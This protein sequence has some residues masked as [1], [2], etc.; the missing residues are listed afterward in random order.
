MQRESHL[1]VLCRLGVLGAV[2]S[3]VIDVAHELRQVGMPQHLPY[4]A[5]FAGM[6]PIMI[7]RALEQVPE[8]EVEW[9][10]TYLHSRLLQCCGGD[11]I[12]PWIGS[13]GNCAPG[14]PDF[15]ERRSAGWGTRGIEHVDLRQGH[16]SLAASKPLALLLAGEMPNAPTDAVHRQDATAR[17]FIAETNEC[18]LELAACK[19]Q[20]QNKRMGHYDTSKEQILSIDANLALG[21]I[22]PK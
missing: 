18:A 13:L 21:V 22:L 7:D 20:L 14:C 4:R 6:I 2:R 12:Q 11:R 19:A 16:L 10:V 9:W 8:V 5:V 17:L 3:L 1:A 15:I